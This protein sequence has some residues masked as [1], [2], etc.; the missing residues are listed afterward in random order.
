MGNISMRKLTIGPGLANA[1][2]LP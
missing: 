2:S 1:N